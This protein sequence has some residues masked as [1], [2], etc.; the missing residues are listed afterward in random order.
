MSSQ[1]G[2][3]ALIVG[4]NY[5]A[6]YYGFYCDRSLQILY[7]T[8]ITVLGM[9]AGFVV[10]SP[11]YTTG[12]YRWGEQLSLFLSLVP[13]PSR[14]FP[15]HLELRLVCAAGP[16]ARTLIFLALGLSAVVPVTHNLLAYGFARARSEMGLGYLLSS[17]GLYIAGALL[18]A[19]R[20]PERRFPKFFDIVGSSHQ[21]F[22]EQVLQ[23][24]HRVSLAVVIYSL[25]PHPC[26]M[27]Q[28]AASSPLRGCT[29]GSLP[30]PPSHSRHLYL[31]P[32]LLTP[33]VICITGPFRLP[34]HITTA[35]WVG[36]VAAT[37][38]EA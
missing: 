27:S 12:A 17:G 25:I 34:W 14:R 6:I 30:L 29:I 38:S 19:V 21:I 33:S 23:P 35:S 28:T 4:S 20:F 2:I 16:L 22:R 5:P 26:D 36:S 24:G 18:Y 15:C 3:V 9:L 11:T 7:T 37:R 13:C 8:V 31:N 32:I 1:V 10:L